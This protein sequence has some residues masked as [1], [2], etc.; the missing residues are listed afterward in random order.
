VVQDRRLSEGG[1]GDVVMDMIKKLNIRMDKRDK[2][3][4]YGMF[5][6]PYCN[7]NVEKIMES[8][9]KQMSCGCAGGTIRGAKQTIHGDAR[10]AKDSRI[11]TIFYRMR[12]RCQNPKNSK[13]K[14]YGGRKNDPVTVCDEWKNDF[15][16]FK[17]WAMDNGYRR[18][19]QIDRKN[20]LKGYSA[21]N[22][23]FV[24]SAI[25]NRNRRNNKLDVESVR[26]IRSLYAGGQYF[27]R[28]LGELYGVHM[29]T[30]GRIVNNEIWVL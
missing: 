11:Y 12:D 4:R 18:P 19:L 1:R 7:K 26:T 5:Y 25:N 9:M 6:C 2:R 20:N 13:F 29:S 3:R 23:R 8:G 10:K 22:C 15:L 28:E 30:I 24:S 14:Y 16:A 21:S 17:K 27:L